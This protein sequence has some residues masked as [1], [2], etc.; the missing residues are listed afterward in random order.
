MPAIARLRKRVTFQRESRTADGA[1]GYALAW[2]TL[3]S[4]WGQNAPE[5]GRE[6]VAAGRVEAD[7]TGILT[8]RSSTKTRAVTTSDKVLIDGVAHNI[9]SISNPDQ[10]NRF[11]EMV[12]ERGVSV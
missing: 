11:L 7:L 1:G 4:V 10:G 5:R 2:T 9:R 12:V 6:R 3:C 8:V